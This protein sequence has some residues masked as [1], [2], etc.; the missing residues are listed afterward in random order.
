MSDMPR[1]GTSS[2]RAR[3]SSRRRRP[4][5]AVARGRAACDLLALPVG[6]RY[7]LL[8]GGAKPGRAAARGRVSGRWL[9]VGRREDLG[10]ILF[11]RDLG[12]NQG[13]G[14]PVADTGMIRISTCSGRVTEAE[15][16]V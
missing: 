1:P 11:S 16:D 13:R 10:P 4:P 2:G 6:R 7:Q 8:H 12:R 9:P 14:G 15:C 5:T 3:V